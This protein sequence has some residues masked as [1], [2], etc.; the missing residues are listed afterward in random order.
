MRA[1]QVRKRTMSPVAGKT[2]AKKTNAKKRQTANETKR[3]PGAIRGGIGARR[4]ELL[5]PARQ[6]W[7]RYRKRTSAVG[8]AQDFFARAPLLFVPASR[9]RACWEQLCASLRRKEGL[10]LNALRPDFAALSLAALISGKT[11]KSGPDTCFVSRKIEKILASNPTLSEKNAEDG[12]ASKNFKWDNLGTGDSC[13]RG[14]FF[15]HHRSLYAWSFN[16]Q[17]RFSGVARI[18]FI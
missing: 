10:F 5:S 11:L 3:K 17:S 8:A 14:D 4:A 6:R 7:E 18:S 2:S 16:D 12:H 1:N 13:A 9:N 15:R